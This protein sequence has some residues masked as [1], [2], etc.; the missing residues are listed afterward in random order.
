MFN[1]IRHIPFHF[2]LLPVF[3]IL[4][5]INEYYGLI[6]LRIAFKYFICYLGLSI[7]LFVVGKFIYRSGVKS[8]L[9]ATSFLLIF[10]FWGWFHDLIKEIGFPHF[11]TSYSFLL[12]VIGILIIALSIRLKNQKSIIRG[13]V[14]LNFLFTIF[15]MV[16]IIQLGGKIFSN[17]DVNNLS[18]KEV[19]SNIDI[20][21]IND[22][23]KPDVFF[24]VFDEYASSLSLKR[25]LNFDN[26]KLDSMMVSNGFY[27]ARR[28][29]SNYNVTPLSVSSTFNLQYFSQNYEGRVFGA[30]DFQKGLYTLGKSFIPRF[31]EANGYKVMSFALDPL[32]RISPMKFNNGAHKKIFFMHTFLGRVIKDIFWNFSSFSFLHKYFQRNQ[33]EN[34]AEIEAHKKRTINNFTDLKKQMTTSS[35]KPKFVYAHMLTPHMPFCWDRNGDPVDTQ[36]SMFDSPY[37]Y[38]EQLQFVNKLISEIIKISKYTSSRPKVVIIEGDHGYRGY[39][40]VQADRKMQF[41]NLNTFY[42]SDGNYELL[43]DSISPVNTFRVVLNKYF[44][45]DL[46]MLKDSSV[47]VIN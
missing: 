27:I 42:F 46:Q 47:F 10:F 38:V 15:L 16:S 11:F 1:R 5:I 26:Y 24:I 8:A 30:K 37:K 23:L 9:W 43:Y 20:I 2:I 22:S 36:M 33:D 18:A 34:I 35:D 39:T 40:S 6:S 7:F 13:T 3:F 17:V 12:P 14:F 41:M 25:F 32:N 29:M 44:K 28:S 4:Q 19:D 31:F 45:Q 21:P